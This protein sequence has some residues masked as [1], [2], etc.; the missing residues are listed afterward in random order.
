MMNV[1]IVLAGL[2]LL[3][4]LILTRYGLIN[5]EVV[6]SLRDFGFVATVVIML[7]FVIST[8]IFFR[9]ICI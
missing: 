5:E 2:Y 6:E 8:P 3:L 9:T 1:I 4:G 7:A